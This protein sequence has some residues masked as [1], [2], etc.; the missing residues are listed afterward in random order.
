MGGRRGN[1]ERGAGKNLEGLT[2]KKT[3]KVVGYE[4]R[5]EKGRKEKA[6]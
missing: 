2:G 5:H 4:K 1:V 3:R 6:M